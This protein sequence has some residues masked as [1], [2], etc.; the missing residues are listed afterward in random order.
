ML[1]SQEMPRLWKSDASPSSP[2]GVNTTFKVE[3]QPFKVSTLGLW[4]LLIPH[5]SLFLSENV[6]QTHWILSLF[7]LCFSFFYFSH[8]EREQTS[9][10]WIGRRRVNVGNDLPAPP[11]FSTPPEPFGQSVKI[12]TSFQALNG[13]NKFQG[14]SYLW[15]Q[16]R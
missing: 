5:K 14:V 6:R 12:R 8:G 10:W 7:L 11:R 15:C 16:A 9:H 1:L 13:G 3:K 4:D 2:P